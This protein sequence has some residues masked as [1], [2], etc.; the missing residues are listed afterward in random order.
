MAGTVDCNAV[1]VAVAVAVSAVAVAVAAAAAAAA[2][3]VVAAVAVA[4]VG[5]GCLLLLLLLFLLLSVF[6]VGTNSWSIL[7]FS[8][9]L[10]TRLCH[11]SCTYRLQQVVQ[12]YT[13][14][15]CRKSPKRL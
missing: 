13:I 1:A 4:V 11:I 8:S 14:H 7:L 2:A 6:V 9:F 10:G 5:L 12:L 3:A 15:Y